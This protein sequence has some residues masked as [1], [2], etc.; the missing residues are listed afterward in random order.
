M[1]RSASKPAFAW[2]APLLCA[3]AAAL[4]LLTLSTVQ[5]AAPSSLPRSPETLAVM[6][7]VAD[8]QLAN[9]AEH[10]TTDWTQAA[11]YAGIM[12][13]A[14]ISRSPRFENALLKIGEEQN[15]WQLGPRPYHA[16]DHAVGQMYAELFFRRHDPK[17]IAPMR[18]RFDWILAHPKEGTLEFVGDD[19]GDRWAWCDSLFMAPPAWARLYAATHNSAYLEYMVA[20]WWRTS[21][22]LYDKEEHL[23]FRDS[24]YFEKREENGRKVFWSRGNGW[25]MAGLARVLE[26]LPERHPAHARFVQQF[27]EMADKIVQL[28]QPDGLWRASLLDAE[29]YPLQETSGS[30]FYTFALAWGVNHGLLDAA[31]FTPA[32]LR[33]WSALVASVQA[34]GKLI[35]VQPIG[36]D[37]R[38]FDENHS[39]V[40]GVGAFLLAGSEIYRMAGGLSP[41]QIDAA[42]AS[43][44]TASPG[45]KAYARFVPE[46][47]DDFAWENDRIAF[48]MYGPALIKGE[49]TISSG[50]DVWVKNTPRL[51]IDKWYAGDDYHR[52]HGE[53]LD[54]YSVGTSRGCGGLG[55]WDGGKL[56]TSSN[57]AS[58]RVLENGPSRVAFELTYAPWNANGR[59]ISEV[60]RISLAAGEHFN[61]IESTFESPT[62]GPLVIGIGI[63]KRSGEGG[64]WQEQAAEGSLSYWEPEAAPNGHIA[65]AV[66]L[67]RPVEH[68]EDTTTDRLALV[69]AAPGQPFVYRAGAGW[70][71]GGEFRDARAWG[72]YVRRQVRLN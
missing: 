27:R 53:G 37:P 7:R 39:D 2:L 60:K 40:F 32:V 23:Y 38:R 6:E 44:R 51:V 72:A 15:A 20:H 59:M 1:L 55:V 31:K 57:F 50:I 49:G 58:W 66:L 12:A 63:A 30:G 14:R 67:G 33:G 45:A 65:C 4:T 43:S 9:P 19:R 18:E 48:R 25:V 10:P 34:D 64:Q 69:T 26:Y 61:R 56:Y 24:T 5:A 62:P 3:Q 35:H 52:D 71:K 11:G 46:R 29:H 36:E 42:A 13:L 21:D 68:F 70:S 47:M 8:W 54:A 28:Q 41:S 22:Y 17:M 16:D